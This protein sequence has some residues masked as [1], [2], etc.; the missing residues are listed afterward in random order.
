M[1]TLDT[2]LHVARQTLLSDKAWMLFVEIP[3]RTP[4]TIRVVRWPRAVFGASK[5][6]QAC[7]VEIDQTVEES[8]EGALPQVQVVLPNISRIA[9]AYLEAEEIQGRRL[10]FWLQHESTVFADSGDAPF[11]DTLRFR[12]RVLS[13]TA[14]ERVVQLTCGH[15]AAATRVPARVFDQSIAP[16]FASRTIGGGS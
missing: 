4:G 12:Y 15:P 11:I 14:T 5:W 7:Q 10:T 1:R 2:P 6:W 3:L 8:T 13:A 16:I 9:S